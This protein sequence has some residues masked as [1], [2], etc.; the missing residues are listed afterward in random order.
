MLLSKQQI[1]TY[2]KVLNSAFKENDSKKCI[3]IINKLTIDQL[4]QLRINTMPIEIITIRYINIPVLDTLSKKGGALHFDMKK[5][6]IEFLHLVVKTTNEKNT[7][8]LNEMFDIF[9]NMENVDLS[10]IF[11]YHMYTPIT[12]KTIDWMIKICDKYKHYYQDQDINNPESF[13]EPPI[14]GIAKIFYRLLDNLSHQY[15]PKKITYIEKFAF[16]LKSCTIYRDSIDYIALP[17]ENYFRGYYNYQGELPFMFHDMMEIHNTYHPNCKEIHKSICYNNRTFFDYFYEQSGHLTKY[18]INLLDAIVCFELDKL[19]ADQFL[20]HISPKIIYICFYDYD[21][22]FLDVNEEIE[23]QCEEFPILKEIMNDM[24]F[25][26]ETVYY[27]IKLLNSPMRKS[28]SKYTKN[29]L[30]DFITPWTSLPSLHELILDKVPGI[31]VDDDD[32]RKTMISEIK[33]SHVRSYCLQC[34]KTYVRY[35]YEIIGKIMT[36]NRVNTFYC[37]QYKKIL[38][39]KNC[40]YNPV[41]FLQIN[42]FSFCSKECQGE[43]YND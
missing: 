38:M 29:M 7:N 20:F 19:L 22:Y 40:Q 27:I 3:N 17:L 31:S 1:K 12:D 14:T 9:L 41:S 6:F 21:I 24:I 10:Y 39:E 36:Y 16:Y 4:Q 28:M 30:K 35:K 34:N 18:S 2:Q 26:T 25:S 42:K 32:E 33:N 8:D 37:N 43:F 13:D 5:S 15:D 11:T 23:K